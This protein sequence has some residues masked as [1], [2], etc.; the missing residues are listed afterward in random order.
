MRH[1]DFYSR[2]PPAKSSSLNQPRLVSPTIN[3]SPILQSTLFL[4]TTYRPIPLL[5]LE[6]DLKNALQGAVPHPEP[7]LPSIFKAQL[8][9][10]EKA[11]KFGPDPQE[12][13]LSNTGGPV[14]AKQDLWP[15]SNFWQ[16]NFRQNP[17]FDI[18]I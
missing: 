6:P 13:N 18:E 17:K 11:S 7:N 3:R 14:P 12:P 10:F 5:P 8:S 2:Y 16:G 15:N 4:K 1:T 9:K